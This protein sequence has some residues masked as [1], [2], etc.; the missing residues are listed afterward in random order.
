MEWIDVV[1]FMLAVAA[2]LA[3]LGL[4]ALGHAAQEYVEQIKANRPV[5]I[6]GSVTVT[7]AKDGG[8]S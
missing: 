7:S 4:L 2:V 3:S 8:P 6:K 5:T 1:L